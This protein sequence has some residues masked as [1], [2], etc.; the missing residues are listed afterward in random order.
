MPDPKLRTVA[1]RDHNVQNCCTSKSCRPKNAKKKKFQTLRVTQ[2]IT[3]LQNPH[4]FSWGPPWLCVCACV[5]FI[6]KHKCSLKEDLLA[7]IRTELHAGSAVGFNGTFR[8]ATARWVTALAFILRC[9]KSKEQ[10]VQSTDW[11]NQKEVLSSSSA[12]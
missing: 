7:G 12:S 9:K 4:S 5:C 1:F 3:L 10:L 8:H 6:G 11:C 2:Q